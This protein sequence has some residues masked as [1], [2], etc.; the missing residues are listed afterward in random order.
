[1]YRLRWRPTVQPGGP[2]VGRQ[3]AAPPDEV[4]IGRWRGMRAAATLFRRSGAGLC[5]RDSG[6]FRLARNDTG[7]VSL[8]LQ[9][10][11]KCLAGV[12]PPPSPQAPKSPPKA[13]LRSG[14]NP[15]CT[16]EPVLIFPS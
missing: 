5:I 3:S 4:V 9:A 12:A 1:L 10:P 11:R 16:P 13:G 2:Q 15:G 6:S 7:A 14:R 8:G